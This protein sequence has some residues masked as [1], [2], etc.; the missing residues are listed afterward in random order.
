MESGLDLREL[1]E[2]FSQRCE[3]VLFSNPNNPTGAVYS[4]GEIRQIAARPEACVRDPRSAIPGLSDG[5][6]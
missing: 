5:R 6:A 4:T 3:A 2:A 1:E